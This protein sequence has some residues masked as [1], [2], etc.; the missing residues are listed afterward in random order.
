MVHKGSSKVIVCISTDSHGWEYRIYVKGVNGYANS[1]FA[2][3]SHR[4]ARGAAVRVGQAT[5]WPV[6]DGEKQIWP[7]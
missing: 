6:F 7:K 2:Y 5:G 4:G 1:C 3:L